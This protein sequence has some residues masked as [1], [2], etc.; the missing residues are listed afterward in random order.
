MTRKRRATLLL[1][2]LA[3][4]VP[5]VLILSVGTGPVSI[6]PADILSILFDRLGLIDTSAHD[7]LRLIIESIRLP[8]TLT[9]FMVGGSLAIAGASMQGLFRN[10]LADPS[11][12]GVASGAALGASVAIVLGETLFAGIAGGLLHSFSI[13]LMAFLGGIV[14]TGLVYRIGDYRKWHISCHHVAGRCCYQCFGWRR[15]RCTDVYCR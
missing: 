12:I 13:S 14:T 11:I 1:T 9:G 8:R 10:P 3:V 4:L 15:Y 7:H 2:S 6:S 5:I